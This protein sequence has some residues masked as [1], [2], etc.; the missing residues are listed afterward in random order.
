MEYILNTWKNRKLTGIDRITLSKPYPHPNWFS[1]ARTSIYLITCLERWTTWFLIF[2]W[3]NIP[4]EIKKKY[5]TIIGKLKIWLKVSSFKYSTPFCHA[6]LKYW[7]AIK[8]MISEDIIR[9]ENEIIWNNQKIWLNKHMIS[10][11]PW[12]WSG[13]TYI[14]N[15]LNEDLSFISHDIF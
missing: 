11:K 3:G 8:P 13:V 7:Q 4:L 2:I 12:H 15:L 5:T 9:K 10:L 1:T 14:K 6:I